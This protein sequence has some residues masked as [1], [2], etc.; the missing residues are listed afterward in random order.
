M[1]SFPTV[2]PAFW[3]FTA[4][5]SRLQ[6]LVFC[7]LI[8]SPILYFVS[9]RLAC[10]VSNSYWYLF[11]FDQVFA[12]QSS[13]FFVVGLTLVNRYWFI[14]GT[15]WVLALTVLAVTVSV[16]VEWRKFLAALIYNPLAIV[17]LMS[18]LGPVS[19]IT[20]TRRGRDSSGP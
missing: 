7:P 8:V 18:V 10:L 1:K 4:N 3:R 11:R 2:P 19:S 17:L 16:G 9:L 13:L 15:C 5:W 14:I 12:F 20:D 6:R